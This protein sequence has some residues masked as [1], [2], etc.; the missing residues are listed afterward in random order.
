MDPPVSSDSNHALNSHWSLRR[1]GWPELT[2]VLQPHLPVIVL[3][4]CTEAHKQCLGK[5]ISRRHFEFRRVET[6]PN[7][8]Q[9]A[10]CDPSSSTKTYLNGHQIPHGQVIPLNDRDLIGVGANLTRECAEGAKRSFLYQIH[11]PTGV[12]PDGGRVSPT[13]GLADVATD[14]EDSQ[15]SGDVPDLVRGTNLA[16]NRGPSVSES[17]PELE[18]VEMHSA[19][20]SKHVDIVNPPQTND[21]NVK[22]KCSVIN[23]E[24]TIVKETSKTMTAS[25]SKDCRPSNSKAGENEKLTVK[26]SKLSSKSAPR[27]K[28]GRFLLSSEDEDD[29]S[30]GSSLVQKPTDPEKSVLRDLMIAR[31]AKIYVKKLKIPSSKSTSAILTQDDRVTKWTETSDGVPGLSKTNPD[32]T[33]LDSIFMEEETAPVSATDSCLSGLSSLATA[34]DIKFEDVSDE[35][36]EVPMTPLTWA[37]KV[38]LKSEEVHSSEEERDPET[39]SAMFSQSDEVFILE[40]DSDFMLAEPKFQIK[41]EVPD[42]EKPSSEIERDDD[43]DE[44]P[45]G[46]D[47][48]N[49][50]LDEPDTLILSSQDSDVLC[51]DDTDLETGQK[52]LFQMMLNRIKREQPDIQLTQEFTIDDEFQQQECVEQSD[53]DMFDSERPSRKSSAKDLEEEN[54]SSPSLLEGMELDSPTTTNEPQW[55]QIL[56]AQYDDEDDVPMDKASKPVPKGDVSVSKSD[57]KDKSIQQVSGAKMIAPL[58]M[59]PRRTHL[60]GISAVTGQRLMDQ[61]EAAEANRESEKSVEK[62]SEKTGATFSFFGKKNRPV[63]KI[64]LKL[65]SRPIFGRSISSNAGV[66]APKPTKDAKELRRARLREIAE[67]GKEDSK[68]EEETT[69][70]TPPVNIK[71][72]SN[73]RLS[74][75]LDQETMCPKVPAKKS[76][77]NIRTASTSKVTSV[78]ANDPTFKEPTFKEPKA[79]ESIEPL[80]SISHIRRVAEKVRDSDGN[81]I[82][83]KLSFNNVISNC[84]SQDLSNLDLPVVEKKA[85]NY[86]SLIS[87]KS[88]RQAKTVRWKPDPELTKVKYIEREGKGLKVS[89]SYKKGSYDMAVINKEQAGDFELCMRAVLNWN[90]MWL[91][92]QKE[93]KGSPPI[94]GKFFSLCHVPLSFSSYSEYCN[95]FYPLLLH[96][97]WSTA[98]NDYKS[99][100]NS[101][102]APVS[103]VG[104]QSDNGPNIFC[105]LNFLQPLPSNYQDGESLSDGWLVKV[106]LP[107]LNSSKN[108]FKSF[109]GYIESLRI[110]R[111]TTADVDKLQAN[112]HHQP[113]SQKHQFVGEYRVQLKAFPDTID[114]KRLVRLEGISLIWSFLRNL[115]AIE[116]TTKSEL[117][118]PILSPKI[119]FFA[120]GLGNDDIRAPLA[121]LPQIQLLNPGQLQVVK[122]VAR[123]C[124]VNMNSP[125]IS[126]V[127]GPPGTGKTSTIVALILQIHSRWKQYNP[128]GALP[129]IL[130]TAPSNTAVDEI[131]LRIKDIAAENGFN[132]VRIGRERVVHPG[133]RDYVFE[134]LREKQLK[135]RSDSQTNRESVNLEIKR[136]QENMN[137]LGESLAKAK[138]QSEIDLLN[139]KIK[140]ESNF[141]TRA[142]NSLTTPRLSKDFPKWWREVSKSIL[143]NADIIAVTLNSS[144][145]KVLDQHFAVNQSQVGANPHRPFSICIMDEASQ[146]SEPEALIPLRLGFTKM[147]LVGDP[148]QLPA[149]VLSNEAKQ[150]SLHQSLF[151]R[152]HNFFETEPAAYQT[153]TVQYRMHKEIMD[154]PSRYFYGRKLEAGPQNR[155][156]SLRPYLLLDLKPQSSSSSDGQ[157]WN[158]D[159]AVFV[160]DLAVRLLRYQENRGETTNIGIITFYTKMRDTINLR[161]QEKGLNKPKS[162]QQDILVRTVDGFQGSECDIVIM[163]CVR[164]QGHKGLGFLGQTERLNVALTRAR[165][166]LYVVMDVENFQKGNEMWRSLI[167]NARERNLLEKCALGAK[168]RFTKE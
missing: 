95:S 64:G 98:Y 36:L 102:L 27:S 141:I 136:R 140:V 51:L 118:R 76:F 124:T 72:S 70:L 52:P 9:W 73:S 127:Q 131:T 63:S 143:E 32:P 37:E 117:I 154:W 166:A 38:M 93:I 126:L 45:L 159:E 41:Q 46:W 167:N 106:S 13:A 66:S 168:V 133:I 48:D 56:Y 14:E 125:H 156:S 161:L 58:P 149:T 162:I 6:S 18:S 115:K 158:E 61:Q 42:D 7:G 44:G 30:N 83:K 20:R 10:I 119:N 139:R 122:T 148:E 71:T 128:T 4:R 31:Q 151:K 110:R 12:T 152:F 62:S 107:V 34:E 91:R 68:P 105:Y 2:F 69:K 114:A 65:S 88:V 116:L 82:V 90:A 160:S 3:G 35:P 134:H 49:E 47:K 11:G 87:T 97:L 60:R 22:D 111:I 5:Q 132:I 43:R 59:P 29:E 150:M 135:L 1:I 146:C 145:T 33:S 84:A 112:F 77:L 39:S 55:K 80:S 85:L 78:N 74:S 86:P 137:K 96:E 144:M 120:T 142:K 94:L 103:F 92:E 104:M 155:D 8:I 25:L 164:T 50:G 108:A 129:R 81:L 21:L 15:E 54:D 100:C 138:E 19:R 26:R 17:N 147:V 75:F 113:D 99:R 53:M 57:P 24:I 123:S 67:R 157:I 23:E 16:L 130:L 153:L 101:V 79:K 28:R 163:S 109:I 40:D 89:Q 121:S 165:I